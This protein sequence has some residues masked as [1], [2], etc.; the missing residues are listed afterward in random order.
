MFNKDYPIDKIEHVILYNMEGDMD[1][2]ATDAKEITITV[3]LEDGK[4]A[5]DQS[6][7]E[8]IK[9]DYLAV[10]FKNQCNK[11]KTWGTFDPEHP[12]KYAN[13]ENNCEWHG[14][15][16][17]GLPKLH[18]TVELPRN[19]SVYVFN[20]NDGDINIDG[21]ENVVFA[22]NV[23]GSVTL[24]NVNKVV[25]GT[26]VNGD[27]FVT[28]NSI[29]ASPGNFNTINGDID[30]SLASKS[31]LN[32][33]FKSFQGDLYTDLEAVVVSEAPKAKVNL[34]AGDLMKIDEFTIVKIGEGGHDFVMET[35]NGNAYLRKK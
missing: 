16:M 21:M 5:E 32:A 23:N 29:P 28:Y 34:A 15:E 11:N 4:L 22:Q 9:H 24:Q 17:N 14:F 7:A 18:F 25:N 8:M 1:I 27:V 13:P 12:F 19:L 6:I 30:I 2:V 3:T 35:F 33:K 26:T 31:S 10:Y 20:I